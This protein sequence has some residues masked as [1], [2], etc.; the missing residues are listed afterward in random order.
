[1]NVVGDCNDENNFPHKFL[2]TN[3]QVSKIWK[4]FGNG[5]PD[6]IKFSKTQLFQIIESGGFAVYDVTEPLIKGLESM[7]K[8]IVNKLKNVL[9]NKDKYFDTIKTVTNST[10]VLRVIKNLLE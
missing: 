8:F 2:L 7:A 3:T 10:K 9:N 5:S 6:N 1:M 4:A